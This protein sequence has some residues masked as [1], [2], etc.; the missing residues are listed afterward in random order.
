MREKVGFHDDKRHSIT[1]GFSFGLTS[2]IITT[3]GLMVGLHS[4]THS[5]TAVIG[6]V[7]T[8]AVAD[9]FS[10]ALGI[11][12]SEESEGKHS[13]REIWISTLST[14]VAKCIF[15]ASFI[16]PV[17]LFKLT[18]AIWMSIGYGLLLLGIFSFFLGKQQN[19]RP[20]KVI[21]EHIT[22]A[23]TVIAVSHFLGDLIGNVLR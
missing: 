10:D 23:G 12:I 15:A 22:I 7:L 5:R 4:G 21:F 16:V 8:I 2:A 17:L 9:A 13:E 3:L 20:G 18:S 19:A 6:G 14:F 1:T 11:H